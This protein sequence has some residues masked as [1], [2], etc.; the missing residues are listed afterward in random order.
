[1]CV[2]RRILPLKKT[3]KKK[4]SHISSVGV[5]WSWMMIN[6]TI[7]FA[8][9]QNV[10]YCDLVQLESQFRAFFSVPVEFQKSDA[11]TI[12]ILLYRKKKKS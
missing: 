9:L 7:R 8:F 4:V 5:C 11:T 3:N 1:M 2:Q 10:Y 12:D 6:G